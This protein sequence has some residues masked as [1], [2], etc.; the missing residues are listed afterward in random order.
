MIS[1]SSMTVQDLIFLDDLRSLDMPWIDQLVNSAASHEE[2]RRVWTHVRCWGLNNEDAD[3]LMCFSTFLPD[4]MT[5]V[6]RIRK[7]VRCI[8]SYEAQ[9]S[10]RI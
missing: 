9:W 4:L 10:E 5:E 8:E 7:L 1:P 2:V 6:G 3:D